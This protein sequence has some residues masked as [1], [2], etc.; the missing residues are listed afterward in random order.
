MKNIILFL[1]ITSSIS[2]F[3]QKD[4][5]KNEMNF[6]G[7]YFGEFNDIKNTKGT[8]EL[9]LYQSQNGYSD[10][11]ILIKKNN[12]EIISGIIRINGNGK[13]ISGNFT[14]SKIK[15]INWNSEKTKNIAPKD[16]YECGW[17]LFGE[18]KDKSGNLIR[19]KA[20]P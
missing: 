10:G 6:S 4:K 17:N 15:N 8:I 5:P 11:I 18:F 9:F 1:I 7:E 16:S 3:S 20:V 12:T 13:F 2:T 14:P 19:G